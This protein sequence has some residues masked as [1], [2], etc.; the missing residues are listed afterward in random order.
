ML[1]LF[2]IAHL[3]HNLRKVSTAEHLSVI[4]DFLIARS[5]Q[6][7]RYIDAHTRSVHKRTAK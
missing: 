4:D 2:I 7:L 1:R 6:F 3:A 5:L